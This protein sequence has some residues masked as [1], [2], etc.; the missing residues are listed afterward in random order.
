M[1]L[2]DIKKEVDDEHALDVR[3]E[4]FEECKLDVES[5]DGNDV[6]CRMFD[7]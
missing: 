7:M 4:Y 5:K 3:M 2:E 6:L 1:E